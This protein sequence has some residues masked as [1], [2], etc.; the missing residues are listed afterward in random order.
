[1]SQ[2][3]STAVS[4]GLPDGLPDRLPDGL[5]LAFY[6]DDFTGSTDA[7]EVMAFA[8]LP[9][10]LFVKP[11]TPAMLQRFANHRGIGI[12]GTARSR[13]PEWMDEHLP[14]VLQ[15][16]FSLHAPLTQYKVCS[17]FDSSAAMGSIGRAIDL[18]LPL[19]AEAWSPLVVGA[20]QL[21]RWQSFG[22]LFAGVGAV[23]YRLDRHPTMSR[24][25]MTPMLE[26]DLA[27]HLGTQTRRSVALVD[28]IDLMAGDSDTVLRSAV[29]AGQIVSFDVIDDA[30]Q[31]EV[32]RLVWQNRG[33][34]LF[35]A[36]SSGLQY[37]LVAYWR[38]LGLLA[39]ASVAVAQAAATVAAP[40]D[41]LLVVSGSCSPATA[42][43]IAC[44][45][46]AGFEPCRVDVLRIADA[47]TRAAEIARVIAHADRALRQRRDVII[48]TAQSPDDPAIH[49]LAQHCEASAASMADAQQA[50]GDALGEI[51]L[52]LTQRHTLP[53]L[54]LAGG[55]TSGRIVDH[56]PIVALE[57]T[58]PLARGSPICR[59]YSA[60]ARF[61]TMELVL[62]GGQIGERDF[63]VSAKAGTAAS[64]GPP[65]PTVGAA[66]ADFQDPR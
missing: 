15:T 58:S 10:V 1:M 19:A 17:T 34:G 31:I 39:P 47:A 63:F 62:K 5:L 24:H 36:S 57:A 51:V 53:R 29:A 11:P 28:V 41:C 43:Q 48:F 32:G 40:V 12:A 64:A 46:D 42:E 3:P 26:S 60:D 49:R 35:S 27:R 38:S 21:R 9:T 14:P 20:P 59:A 56:L 13:S 6:G 44:A 25:P 66:R 54:V 7:M 52:A 33:K 30:T 8:G 37:A 18:A 65:A 4:D 45:I 61:D 50:L 2:S 16:L 23:R 22:N 55:D